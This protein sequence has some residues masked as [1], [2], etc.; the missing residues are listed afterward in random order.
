MVNARRIYK[1]YTVTDVSTQT[2]SGKYR[3]RV[4]IMALDGTHT[5]SQRFLDSEIFRT[6]AEA[7]E[8]AMTVA[9]AWINANSGRD[10]LA[11]PT[12]FSPLE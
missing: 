4:A 2:E 6:K 11:L 12:N 1:G 5:R 7:N 3:A 10:Q 9:M 8:R